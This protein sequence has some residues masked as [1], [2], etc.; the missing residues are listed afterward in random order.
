MARGKNQ[1]LRLL[2]SAKI[3]QEETDDMHRLTM[4]QLCE[5]LDALNDFEIAN[6]KLRNL[7][8]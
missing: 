2:Y 7:S 3:M 5:D 4:P 6:L 1:K 8:S